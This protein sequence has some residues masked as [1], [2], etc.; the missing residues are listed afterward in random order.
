MFELTEFKE[1]WWIVSYNGSDTVI[2]IR[3]SNDCEE[4]EIF[5]EGF[6]GEANGL[7]DAWCKDQPAGI[8]RLTVEPVYDE[9]REYVEEVKVAE[10]KQLYVFPEE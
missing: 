7:D 10:H 5:S 1:H 6:N 9:D 8:Y 4:D 2:I 3:E